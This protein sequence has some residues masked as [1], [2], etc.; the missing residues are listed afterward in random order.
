MAWIRREF[1]AS[2]APLRV[3]IRARDE[4]LCGGQM[5]GWQRANFED[6]PI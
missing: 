2:C 1:P 5:L 6:P 4:Q 3:W